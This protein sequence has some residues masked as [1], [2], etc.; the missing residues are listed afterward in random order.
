MPQPFRSGSNRH[1]TQTVALSK[2]G[3][4]HVPQRRI[5]ETGKTA[6]DFQVH[7]GSLDYYNPLL[8]AATR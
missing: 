5:G 8:I 4:G 3:R 2:L 6:R 1:V 7:V